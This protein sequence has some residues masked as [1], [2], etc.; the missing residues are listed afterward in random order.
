MPH[1]AF[2]KESKMDNERNTV[3]QSGGVNISGGTVTVQG[4]VVGRDKNRSHRDF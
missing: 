2:R 3:G 1:C 4:D